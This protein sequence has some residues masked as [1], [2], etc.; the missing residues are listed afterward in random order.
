[1][2]T[3]V[4]GLA[5]YD[6]HQKLKAGYC[7]AEKRLIT[8]DELVDAAVSQLLENLE[9]EYQSLPFEEQKK[10]ILYQGLQDFYERQPKCCGA[11]GKNGTSKYPPKPSRIWYKNH[12]GRNI[13]YQYRM[14]GE[15]KYRSVLM[16]VGFCGD[17][18]HV[19]NQWRRNN[20]AYQDKWNIGSPTN[21]SPHVKSRQK[22]NVRGK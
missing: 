18:A 5:W 12:F 17:K 21:I 8:D 16:W 2:V 11:S 19:D 15:K 6:Y 20:K 1:M 13:L 7:F 22:F 9:R 14:D 4:G 10:R 3:L